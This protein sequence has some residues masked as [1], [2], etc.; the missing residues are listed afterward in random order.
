MKKNYF[1]LA[2]LTEAHKAF[3]K[4]YATVKTGKRSI[5]Q[6]L[7]TLINES[8]QTSKGDTKKQIETILPLKEL[9]KDKQSRIKKRVQFSLLQHDYD[10]L[11]KLSNKTD[12]SIQH[13]II[14]MVRNHLY[15]KHELLGNEIEILRKS[16]YEL[17]RIG[18][19]I[20]QIAK[21][22]NAGY[23]AQIDIRTVSEK[24]EKHT[25]LVEK[26]LKDNLNRF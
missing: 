24:I 1:K 7:L 3:L 10:N 16:N 4:D 8:M 13:Y 20:N 12:S 11:E 18:V 23:Q 25:K 15:N 26:V 6:G 17:Y 14:C 5:T 2:G 9:S 22:L 21:Q 19:N